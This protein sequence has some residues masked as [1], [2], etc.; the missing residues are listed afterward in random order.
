[1]KEDFRHPLNLVNYIRIYK[2]IVYENIHKNLIEIS[3][4]S[5]PK[6]K[7][8]SV[9][10]TNRPGVHKSRVV[11]NIRSTEHW[12][13]DNINN[14]SKTGQYMCNLFKNI[15]STN[16]RKYMESVGLNNTGFSIQNIELLKYT[17]DGHYV[18]HHDECSSYH[19]TFSCIYFINDDYEGGELSFSTLTNFDKPPH[20]T[21]PPEANSLII[22][23]S[24]FLYQHQINPIITGERYSII[25]WISA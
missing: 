21:I 25:G 7:K 18:F 9:N 1:M 5:I 19:R 2:N 14:D 15:F 22:F 4:S 6:F 8:A 11:E 3:K 20:L 23:P 17:K 12:P 10:E 24:N 13:L 16:I